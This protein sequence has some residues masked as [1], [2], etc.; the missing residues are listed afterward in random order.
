MLEFEKFWVKTT[1]T[2]RYSPPTT[3]SK[4]INRFYRSAVHVTLFFLMVTSVHRFDATVGI[5]RPTKKTFRN[6]IS[7]GLRRAH[8]M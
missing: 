5:F 6:P 1:Q 7:N 3:L 4:I 2:S 8:G